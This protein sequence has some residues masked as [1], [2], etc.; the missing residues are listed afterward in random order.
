M[1]VSAC[2]EAVQP[3]R[4]RNYCTSGSARG[5]PGNRRPYR[6]C[7]LHQFRPETPW[8]YNSWDDS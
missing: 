3:S 7:T 8:L 4:M 6:G 5:A 1:T 2:V